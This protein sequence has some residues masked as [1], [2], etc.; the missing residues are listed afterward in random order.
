VVPVARGLGMGFDPPVGA[1]ALRRTAEAEILEPGMVLALTGYVWAEGV[2]S[3]FGRDA[4][5][6]GEDGPEI[7]TSSP[8]WEPR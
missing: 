3:V 8:H 1:P 5:L 2:G 7:L 6:I 4:V